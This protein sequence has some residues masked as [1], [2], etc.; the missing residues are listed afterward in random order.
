MEALT[1]LVSIPLLVI[2]KSALIFLDEADSESET[3]GADLEGCRLIV[4]WESILPL[5]LKCQEIGC[6]DQV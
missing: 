2:N 6:P 5:L 3:E 1:L 4:D